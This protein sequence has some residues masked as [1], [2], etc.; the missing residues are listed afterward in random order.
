MGS[1]FQGVRSKTF[2]L[3][4]EDVGPQNVEKSYG[5]VWEGSEDDQRSFSV[6]LIVK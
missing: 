5:I 3:H 2:L 4:S 1:Q 6:F